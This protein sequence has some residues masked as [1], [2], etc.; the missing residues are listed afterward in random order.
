MSA[1]TLRRAAALMRERAE[2]AVLAT[3]EGAWRVV[4]VGWVDPHG[5]T[6]T[7]K[8]GIQTGVCEALAEEQAEHIASWHPAVAL[9]VADWL[10]SAARAQEL[11][12][13]ARKSQTVFGGPPVMLHHPGWDNALAAAR[14][15]LGD[16]S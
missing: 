9:A 4:G 13:D 8:R 7:V 14:A 2:D 11:L 5:S 1:E 10:D 6:Y 16:A 3:G 12:D 15:Y